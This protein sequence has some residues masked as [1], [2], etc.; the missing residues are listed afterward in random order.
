MVRV[1]RAGWKGVRKEP[2]FTSLNVRTGSNLVDMGRERCAP[3]GLGGELLGWLSTTGRE[4]TV[5]CCGV[6]VVMPQGPSRAPPSSSE[7]Q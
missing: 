3:V 6:V 2:V 7:S 5:K 1:R 4:T